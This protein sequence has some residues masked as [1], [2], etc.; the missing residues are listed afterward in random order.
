MYPTIKKVPENIR[1]G[2][3]AEFK[4]AFGFSD[5]R[6][7]C[8]GLLDI[9]LK[10][11]GDPGQIE[12]CFPKTV[13]FIVAFLT[14]R[15]PSAEEELERGE[16]QRRAYLEELHKDRKQGYLLTT[17]LSTVH[18]S[19]EGHGKLCLCPAETHS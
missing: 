18:A 16:P 12:W 2:E 15:P 13:I 19:S 1:L 6:R 10:K 8:R 17:R 7:D 3:E 5:V 9:V 4:E 11:L 14:S